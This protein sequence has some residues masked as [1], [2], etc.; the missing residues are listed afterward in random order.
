MQGK[1]KDQIEFSYKVCAIGLICI[2]ALVIALGVWKWNIPQSIDPRPVGP[3]YNYWTPTDEDMLTLDSLYN[4]V[5][6]TEE[7]VEELNHSVDR[8]DS[9]LDDM[10]DEQK[11]RDAILYNDEYQMWITGEGDTIYE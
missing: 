4:I 8:I 11:E 10:I 5:R 2:V 7:D 1:R 6:E 3:T 9:K